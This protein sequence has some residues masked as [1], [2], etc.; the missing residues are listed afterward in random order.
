MLSAPVARRRHGSHERRHRRDRGNRSQLRTHVGGWREVLGRQF[1]RR[2]R[3]R[4]VHRTSATGGRRRTRVR[5]RGRRRRRRPHL[6][7]HDG[8]RRQVLGP[9]SRRPARRQLEHQSP[10]AGRRAD[11]RPVD[12]FTP[13]AH[14]PGVPVMLSATASSG[15]AVTFDTWTPGT[16]SVAGNTVTASS[17]GLCGIRASQAGNANISAAPQVLRLVPV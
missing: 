17:V 12:R 13:P 8:G 14:A 10:G 2:T 9:Q 6:R 7:D 5:H 3:R 1:L 15:L 11:R 16:C 4:I